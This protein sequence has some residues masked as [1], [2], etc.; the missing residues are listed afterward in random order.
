MTDVVIE[1]ENLGKKFIIGHQARDGYV[2]LRDV[3]TSNARSL[4]RQTGDLFRG[5]PLIDGESLEEIW[6]LKG[7]SFEVRRGDVVG[8][9][10]RNGAGKSTLLKILSRII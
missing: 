6:A 3:L 5:K 8:V 1:A 9:I 10:G 4:W 2:A 7:V